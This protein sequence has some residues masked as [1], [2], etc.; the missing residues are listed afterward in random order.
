[1]RHTLVFADATGLIVISRSVMLSK[2]IVYIH[3]TREALEWLEMTPQTVKDA[4]SCFH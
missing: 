2:W 1:M 4:G 3:Q